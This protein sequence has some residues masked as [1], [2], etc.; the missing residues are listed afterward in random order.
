M[1]LAIDSDERM[2]VTDNVDYASLAQLY[3]L[4]EKHLRT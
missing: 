3:V 2:H 1:K 4:E